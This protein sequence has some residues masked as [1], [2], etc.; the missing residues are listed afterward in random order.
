[1]PGVWDG[2]EDVIMMEFLN[3]G[4]A[5]FYSLATRC[6]TLIFDILNGGQRG[7]SSRDSSLNYDAQEKRTDGDA[8]ISSKDLGERTSSDCIGSVKSLLCRCFLRLRSEPDVSRIFAWQPS[9]S[10]LVG[11]LKLN[12]D[13]SWGHLLGQSKSAA[14]TFSLVGVSSGCDLKLLRSWL[15]TWWIC[16]GCPRSS[17]GAELLLRL[18]N[19]S[20]SVSG[21]AVTHFLYFLSS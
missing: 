1:V 18:R 11:N 20:L 17:A 12:L 19:T 5:K 10:F 16:G 13:R 3:L 7:K 14:C 2:L 6:N 9:T 15:S 21:N 8:A 4:R